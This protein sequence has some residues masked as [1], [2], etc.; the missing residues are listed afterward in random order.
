MLFGSSSAPSLGIPC[1]MQS[2]QPCHGRGYMLHDGSPGVLGL[3]L[4]HRLPCCAPQQ[5]YLRSLASRRRRSTWARRVVMSACR[6]WYGRKR[7]SVRCIAAMMFSTRSR[8]WSTSRIFCR[9]ASFRHR[10]GRSIISC[11][12]ARTQSVDRVVGVGPRAELPAGAAVRVRAR[13]Q[14]KQVS[15]PGACLLMPGACA[16]V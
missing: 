11:A 10:M 13:Q 2:R 1:G 12:S 7:E 3:A 16:K 9:S 5:Q 8:C 15:L 6:A 4:L 14:T